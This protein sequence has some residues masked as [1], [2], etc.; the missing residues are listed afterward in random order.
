MDDE[1]NG[2]LIPKAKPSEL[3]TQA[4]ITQ[5]QVEIAQ[6]QVEIAKINA[7]SQAGW[8][9]VAKDLSGKFGNYSAAKSSGERRY[10]LTLTIGVLVFLLIIV[11]T[12]ALLTWK[13][14]IGGEPFLFF[15]GTLTGSVLILVTERVKRQ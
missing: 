4:K 7:Q 15:L 10:T 2:A 8:Q 11:G 1:N 9:E 3:E 13:D 6:A 12:L 5:A 14:K